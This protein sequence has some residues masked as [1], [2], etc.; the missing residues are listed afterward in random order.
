MRNFILTTETEHGVRAVST[1][2][3]IPDTVY[4]QESHAPAPGGTT[5]FDT[6]I[7]LTKAEAR[8]VRDAITSFLEFK[9]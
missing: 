7:S 9:P 4:V 3:H 6:L 1:R 8:V 2:W 5:G